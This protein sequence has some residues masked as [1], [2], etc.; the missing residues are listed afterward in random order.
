MHG[1]HLTIPEREVIAQRGAAGQSQ[2]GIQ[3]RLGCHPSTVSRE[4][5]RNAAA[6]GDYRPSARRAWEEVRRGL[7]HPHLDACLGLPSDR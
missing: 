7:A 1:H 4:I 6:N 5:R 3:R 2:A